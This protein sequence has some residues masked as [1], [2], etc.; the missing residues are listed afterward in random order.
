[1]TPEKR[2]PRYKRIKCPECNQ[3]GCKVW[4][5]YIFNGEEFVPD[6]SDSHVNVELDCLRCGLIRWERLEREREAITS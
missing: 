4:I 2:K 6:V 1:M 3:R 5:R